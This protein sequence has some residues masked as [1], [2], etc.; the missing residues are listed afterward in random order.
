LNA[1]LANSFYKQGTI[2]KAIEILP[3][4]IRLFYREFLR[5]P[6]ERQALQIS[7]QQRLI[8]QSYEESLRQYTPNY[9]EKSGLYY[10][11]PLSQEEITEKQRKEILDKR[12]PSENHQSTSFEQYM[13]NLNSLNNNTNSK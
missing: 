11:K 1:K 7:Q 3:N 2:D 13:E 10:E 6:G 4:D 8:R 12:F 9:S 5:T